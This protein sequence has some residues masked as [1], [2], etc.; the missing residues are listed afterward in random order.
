MGITSAAVRFAPRVNPPVPTRAPAPPTRAPAPH[1]EP[2]PIERPT[3]EPPLAA[4]R[5]E[6]SRLHN[7]VEPV[8]NNVIH[9]RPSGR[10]A[11]ATAAG[12][13]GVAG[14][15][16]GGGYLAH[17][18]LQDDFTSL[19]DHLPSLPAL[20]TNLHLPTELPFDAVNPLSAMSGG[21]TSGVTTL[22]VGGLVVFGVVQAVRYSSRNSR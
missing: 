18:T 3:G 16:V 10:A 13:V 19:V 5:S 17:R 1:S 11:A 14:V 9:N 2:H 12:A 8:H 22:L 4:E 21:M 20:P 6:A 15:Y 7:T